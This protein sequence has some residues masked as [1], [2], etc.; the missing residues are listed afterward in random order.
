MAEVTTKDF[1]KPCTT[2]QPSRK[3]VKSEFLNCLPEKMIDVQDAGKPSELVITGLY[4]DSQAS[5]NNHKILL[6]KPHD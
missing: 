2:N 4:I 3:V 6:S 1:I 5:T